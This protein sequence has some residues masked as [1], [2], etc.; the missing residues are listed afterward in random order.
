MADDKNT[1]EATD[2]TE[3]AVKKEQKR[4]AEEAQEALDEYLTNQMPQAAAAELAEV[5]PRLNRESET[6]EN[7]E[8]GD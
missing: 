4:E 1:P 3:D 5:D 7:L 2:E 6:E 8:E